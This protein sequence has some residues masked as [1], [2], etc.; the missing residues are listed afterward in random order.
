MSPRGPVVEFG[1][2]L[3]SDKCGPLASGGLVVAD[4][5]EEKGSRDGLWTKPD[6]PLRLGRRVDRVD[7]SDGLRR[8]TWGRG[9]CGGESCSSLTCPYRTPSG[10]VPSNRNESSA[11]D[12]V[13]FTRAGVDGPSCS[14]RDSRYCLRHR[15]T[16][17][18]VLS[19][20]RGTILR[21]GMSPTAGAIGSDLDSGLCSRSLM[22]KHV[23]QRNT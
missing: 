2:G 7:S 23:V 10:R 20:E 9:E 1:F 15:S 4:A 6:A 13:P 3:V 17:D 14:T 18:L 8:F 22:V 21:C 5:D 12:W 19:T 11:K 16:S